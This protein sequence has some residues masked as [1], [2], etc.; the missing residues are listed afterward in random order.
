MLLREV[1]PARASTSWTPSKGAPS[2][3]ERLAVDQ[4]ELELEVTDMAIVA[5]LAVVTEEQFRAV[6][7]ALE[8]LVGTSDG[9]RAALEKL[10]KLR[11]AHGPRRPVRREEQVG[12]QSIETHLAM[13]GRPHC[14]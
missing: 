5:L 3:V 4:S 1:C 6:E 2:I 11:E 9:A 7:T 13:R 14:P 10:Q 8:A 12:Q